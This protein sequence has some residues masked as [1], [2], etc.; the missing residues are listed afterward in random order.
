[1]TC[2]L[3]RGVYP[4]KQEPESLSADADSGTPVCSPKAEDNAPR[5]PCF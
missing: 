2:D 5:K 3:V 4:E 1:M